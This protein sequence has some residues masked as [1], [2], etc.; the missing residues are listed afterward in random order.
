M[1]YIKEAFPHENEVVIIAEGFLD[2][3][4]VQILKD[5]CE[6]HL[7]G[8]KRIVLEL[9]GLIHV[10]REGRE[11]LRELAKNSLIVLAGNTGELWRSDLREED[12]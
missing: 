5:V 10:S 9:S 7:Q 11:F 3:Q 1:I 2:Y 12:K 6:P 8:R 4:S